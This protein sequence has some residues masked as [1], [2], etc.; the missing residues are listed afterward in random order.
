MPGSPCARPSGP[1]SWSTRSRPC[2]DRR[3]G[4]RRVRPAVAPGPARDRAARLREP[5][6]LVAAPLARR[7]ARGA[8]RPRR[9]SRDR[10]VRHGARRGT[11]HGAGLRVRADADRRR[12]DRGRAALPGSSSS[13]PTCS[14]TRCPRSARSRRRPRRGRPRTPR[15]SPSRS[16]GSILDDLRSSSPASC[17]PGTRVRARGSRS[18]GGGSRCCA[19][20]RSRVRANPG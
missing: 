18:E 3:R 6:L 4:R 12:R 17:A 14:S 20:I 8:R 7:G 15:S 13:A 1:E 2:D 9:G 5:P 19:R 11:R 10:R 16:S